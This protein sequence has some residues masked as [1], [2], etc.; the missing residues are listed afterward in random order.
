MPLRHRL[1]AV[2]VATVWGANFVAIHASLAQFPPFLLIA[3]RFLL[4]A[5]PTI[6]FVP[7]PWVAWRWPI[8]CG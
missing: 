6:L 1:A 2:L 7:R 5:I 3:M 4:V 8:G